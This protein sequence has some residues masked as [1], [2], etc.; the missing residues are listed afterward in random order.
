LNL[1]QAQGNISTSVGR[2]AVLFVDP[3]AGTELNVRAGA[4]ILLRLPKGKTPDVELKLTGG[5]EVRV[6]LPGVEPL[7][8]E[9]KVVTMTVGSG[10]AKVDLTA[11]ADIIV[12]SQA[13]EWHR[14]AGFDEGELNI[15]IP[16]PDI[17]GEINRHVGHVVDDEY[18]QKVRDRV[19]RKVD[20]AMRRAEL[21]MRAA[22]RRLQGRVA[23]G[24]TRWRVDW[25]PPQAGAG[26]EQPSDE[27]RMIILRMLEEKK[28]S[29]EEA[30]TLLAA[31][32]GR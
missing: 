14:S 27:E 15:R 21:K 25:S 9:A 18:A 30:E 31:L 16:M 29:V 7:E 13:D 26:I 32:E 28:I 12:T 3:Q 20:A 1:R 19:Q 6:D 24:P 5:A 2:S 23:I 4:D 17:A 22:E 11:G 10:A 8:G